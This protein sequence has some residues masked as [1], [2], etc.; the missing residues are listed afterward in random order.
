MDSA[1]N[2]EENDIIK[3]FPLDL[4]QNNRKSQQYW[5]E[6][7]LFVA[8]RGLISWKNTLREIFYNIS[9]ANNSVNECWMFPS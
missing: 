3:I 7:L 4:K 2:W 9:N 6:R 5:N 1:R 8:M